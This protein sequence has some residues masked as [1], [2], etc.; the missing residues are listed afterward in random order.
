MQYTEEFTLQLF[1]DH[2]ESHS[3]GGLLITESHRHAEGDDGFDIRHAIL[4]ERVMG[5]DGEDRWT[6]KM[7][8]VRGRGRALWSDFGTT[9]Y[10]L[11]FP[12]VI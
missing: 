5:S 7:V 12:S 11:W 10:C 8:C 3:S 4:W 1:V 2:L 9:Y 6:M